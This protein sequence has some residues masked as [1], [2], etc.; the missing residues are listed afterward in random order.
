MEG[1]KVYLEAEIKDII[2][3]FMAYYV[4]SMSIAGRVFYIGCS[5]NPI[6]RYKEHY[7]DWYSACFKLCRYWLHTKSMVAV[8]TILSK[9][10]DK[11][12]GFIAEN[13]AIRKYSLICPLLNNQF[14]PHLFTTP[15]PNIPKL[16]THKLIAEELNNIKMQLDESN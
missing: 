8:M 7:H 2:F 4:Y 5:S 1:L 14:Y 12:K 13:K 16:R 10:E 15:I 3:A 11:K 9:H 6:R